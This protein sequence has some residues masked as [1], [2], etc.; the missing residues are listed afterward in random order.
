MKTSQEISKLRASLLAHYDQY[1]RRLP[2]RIRPEDRAVGMVVDPYKIWLSEIMC[3]QTTVTAAAPYWYKFLQNWPYVEDLAV[4]PRD[5]V[6][7]AWAGL[8]YY[9]RARNLHACAGVITRDFGGV[10]PNTE[11]ELLKL[12]GIGPYTAAAIASICYGE[13]TNVVDG[14][15][16]RVIA[17][18][19]M[20]DT[21]LPKA[22]A[23]IRDLAGKIADPKRAGDY[24][25]ALMDLGS[26]VCKPKDPK[27][28][29][30]P[31]GFA[32]QAYRANKTA[33][34]PK[35]TK[36]K[37]SPLRYGAVFYLESDGKILLQRRPDKGLLGGMMQ[38]PT[39]EWSAQQQAVDTLLA[40]APIPRNWQM[41]EQQVKHVFTHFTLQLKVFVAE[42]AETGG[43]IWADISRLDDYALPSLMRKTVKIAQ[44]EPTNT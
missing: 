43:G 16:E 38:L 22:K 15:V 8:G 31:W 39:T 28:G 11:S 12:P 6:M 9:A 29:E 4:A 40:H 33:T 44:S 36:K 13:P 3:Q 20:V 7:A 32:C 10:F 1:G 35:R 30:C 14:N 34:Y 24:G 18:L 42:C 23:E 2:W 26:Q 27:C 17:R 5:T 19:R 41:C 25:Q 21:P 37:K